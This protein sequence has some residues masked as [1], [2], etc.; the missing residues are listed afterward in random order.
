MWSVSTA[1]ILLKLQLSRLTIIRSAL[2]VSLFL[3]IILFPV[4]T[5]FIIPELFLK[6]LEKLSVE[7]SLR[8]SKMIFLT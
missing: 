6:I 7:L 1:I 4:N 8:E 5:V 2:M 3:S